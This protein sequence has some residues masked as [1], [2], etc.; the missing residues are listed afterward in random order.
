MPSDHPLPGEP[1]SAQW[2]HDMEILRITIKVLEREG[3]ETE[4]KTARY[5]LREMKTL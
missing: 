5:F 2:T 3:R 1:G 4:L